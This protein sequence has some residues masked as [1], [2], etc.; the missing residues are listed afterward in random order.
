MKQLAIVSGKGGTGK[1]TLSGSFAVLAEGAVIADCDVDAPDLHLL[2]K[3]QVREV[4]KF[5][6]KHVAAIDES[7]CDACGKCAESCRFQAIADFRVD[8]L[9]CE[10]CGV[11]RLVCPVS[12]VE[13]VERLS[14]YAYISDTIY[15]PMVHAELLPG[16][17]TSGKLVA[18][19]R[20]MAR[21]MAK[22]ENRE[23]ILIDGSPGIG[24]PVIAS[25]TGTDLAL[26]VTEPTLSGS[27][28]LDRILGLTE[29]FGVRTLVCVNR[30]DLNPENTRW[31]EERCREA[32]VETVGKIPFDPGALKAVV[33]R[34]PLVELDGPA[35]IAVKG[36]WKRVEAYLR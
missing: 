6:G 18:L 14:G 11:C 32:D 34:K 15:G 29:H 30:H 22:E 31:I 12:A 23:T 26:V 8:P 35:S 19:V 2:L 5:Y 17:E 9:R 1:T 21:G 13:M 28:D 20:E 7:K 36:I 33:L 25:L 24:C 27:H 10:G 3:P 4:R 16:E